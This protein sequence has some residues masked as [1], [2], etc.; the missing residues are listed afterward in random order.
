MDSERRPKTNPLQWSTFLD[1]AEVH[2]EII[3]KKFNCLNGRKK[4]E[5]KW[6]E[7]SNILN[8]MGY[9]SKPVE[10]WQKAVS[11]WRSKVKSKAATIKKEMGKTGGGGP[12]SSLNENEL[13]L[14]AIIGETSI[15][16]VTQEEI[17]IIP[18]ERNLLSCS[19]E[20]PVNEGQ[21]EQVSVIPPPLI[22]LSSAGGEKRMAEDVPENDSKK[23][24]CREKENDIKSLKKLHAE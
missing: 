13:R 16:G 10:K 5:E 11:D 14:L 24:K 23:R 8:S 18:E 20:V 2:P 6:K 17:G 21:K 4:Y 15:R 9:Q 1:F 12:S 22:P 3:T 19:S 7:I